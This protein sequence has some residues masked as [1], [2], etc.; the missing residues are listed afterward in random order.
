M[1]Q[2]PPP[3][4][5]YPQQPPQWAPVPP[6]KKQSNGWKIAT[7]VLGGLFFVS[8]TANV[9]S[10]GS[11]EDSG[12]PKAKATQSA[13]EAADK[14]KAVAPASK[15]PAEKKKKPETA[16]QPPVTITASKAAFKRTVLHDSDDYTSVKVTVAN[17]TDD[18][19]HV[20][21]LYFEVTDSEGV[22]HSA[23]IFGSESDLRAVDL[24][25]GEKAVG[26]ITVKGKVTPVKVYYRK[27][28]F[29][30]SY[31]APVK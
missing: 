9:V 6:P 3:G 28:G 19:I 31:S 14:P 30:T 1:T 16:E 8:C 22:K 18:K 21:P 27:G 20:N 2:P 24:F 5:G 23:E 25:K 26:T 4:Y 7:F 17:N 29:G 11:D 13:A 15:P 10:A 12:S